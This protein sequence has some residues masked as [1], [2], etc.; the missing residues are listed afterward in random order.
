[1]VAAGDTVKTAADT[2]G[3]DVKKLYKLRDRWPKDWQA[4]LAVARAQLKAI[5]CETPVS[6]P[7]KRVREGIRKATAL[8]VA[9]PRHPEI[10]AALHV[11]ATTIHSWQANYAE[12]WNQ[13]YDRAMEAAILLIRSQAGTDQ[14]LNDPADYI[15]RARLCERWARQNDREMFPRT[16]ATTLSSFFETHYIPNRL[17][18]GSKETIKI[19]RD[20][21]RL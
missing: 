18:D 15:R 21:V 16:D 14:V 3:L 1:M 12:L 7:C 9:G 11:T 8:A 5:G 10:A 20:T 17:A 4:E 19:Y 13:E 2:L 6:T